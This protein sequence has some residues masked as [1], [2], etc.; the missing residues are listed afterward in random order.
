MRAALTTTTITLEEFENDLESARNAAANGPVFLT[1]NGVNACVLLTLEEYR[2]IG[3]DCEGIEDLL[4]EPEAAGSESEP[5]R[6]GDG[7]IRPADLS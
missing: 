3:G 2:R 1:E 6:L 5:L 7:P 4:P